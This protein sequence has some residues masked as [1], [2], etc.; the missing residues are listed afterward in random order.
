MEFQPSIGLRCLVLTLVSYGQVM[1]IRVTQSFHSMVKRDPQVISSLRSGP[2]VE[3]NVVTPCINV[4]KLYE[5]TERTL[6]I[7]VN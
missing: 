3:N 7:I 6:L 2:L 5:L 4:S 1:N